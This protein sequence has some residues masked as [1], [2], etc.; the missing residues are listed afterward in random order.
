MSAHASGGRA[1]DLTGRPLV[2]STVF[3]RYNSIV[4]HSP[5]L[6]IRGIVERGDAEVVSLLA[7]NRESLISRS[8]I[9]LGTS[10][11]GRI[12]RC[13]PQSTSTPRI[14]RAV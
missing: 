7:D 14:R 12:E 4:R 5:A 9:P 8:C 6:L 11:G 2:R 10:L 13:S 1:D 3:R